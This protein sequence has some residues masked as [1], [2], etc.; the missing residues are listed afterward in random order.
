MKIN[1]YLK[2]TSL[3]EACNLLN[4][5]PQAILYGGGAWLKVSMK[6]MD[7]VIDLEHVLSNQIIEEKS[8]IVISALT[9]L[10]EIEKSKL[11]QS[12]FSGIVSDAASQIMGISVRNI[13]TIG[14]TIMGRY[15]FSDLLTP[16]LALGTTL[17]FYQSG[18]ISLHDFLTLKKPP[19]DILVSIK[20]PKK[21]QVGYFKK[22]AT[23]ALDFAILNIAI[24]R[25]DD[26]INVAVGSRPGVA[27]IPV[28]TVE[29]INKYGYSDELMSKIEQ[30]FMEECQFGS[31]GK[32]SK[33][34]RLQLAKVYLQRGLNE[35]MTSGN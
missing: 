9:S 3:S 25:N 5:N 4:Q 30:P 23:T 13:A 1:H 21:D 26:F 17:Q 35:V 33:E 2:P 16:L 31:N 6:Q 29:L 34:Y 8:E 28:K 19:R 32:A 22:I 24:C 14:G 20:I 15:G 12:H 27:L 11:L 18:S 7:T 10:H